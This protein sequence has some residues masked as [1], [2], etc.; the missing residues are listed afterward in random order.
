[1]GSVGQAGSDLSTGLSST[2]VTCGQS[3]KDPRKLQNSLKMGMKLP[4]TQKS[5][6]ANL[7]HVL[8]NS[9]VFVLT[10]PFSLSCP[11]ASHISVI[12]CLQGG[13][14]FSPELKLPIQGRV[15]TTSRLS[16]P[17]SSL[18]RFPQVITCNFSKMQALSFQ[19]LSDTLQVLSLHMSHQLLAQLT[20]GLQQ[21][22]KCWFLPCVLAAPAACF[23]KRGRGKCLQRAAFENKGDL[24]VFLARKC[25]QSWTR[26]EHL[27]L[28]NFGGDSE[29]HPAAVPQ[30]PLWGSCPSH[31]RERLLLGEVRAVTWVCLELH[32]KFLF[33]ELCALWAVY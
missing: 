25:L 6:A 8:L 19:P 29:L 15:W 14:G 24:F 5:R 31:W 18:L 17:R 16:P 2:E 20:D 28:G 9:S 1:M 22:C 33:Q 4:D 27:Q 21:Q 26:K 10:D 32:S 30:G 11:F 3:V 13:S 23:V 12:C 7:L